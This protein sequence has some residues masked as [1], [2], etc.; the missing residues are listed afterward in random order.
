MS[1]IDSRDSDTHADGTHHLPAVSFR[2]TIFQSTCKNNSCTAFWK[3]TPLMSVG[4]A[5]NSKPQMAQWHMQQL[6]ALHFSSQKIVCSKI[7]ALDSAS[8]TPPGGQQESSAF[9]DILYQCPTRDL[10]HFDDQSANKVFVRYRKRCVWVSRQ[11][12]AQSVDEI[13]VSIILW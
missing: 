4:R 5:I 8:I 13:R 10:A 11:R 1:T 3:I 6:R 2:W 7:H 9:E 12:L